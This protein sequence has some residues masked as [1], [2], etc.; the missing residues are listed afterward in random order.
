[1][2]DR[3]AVLC[4]SRRPSSS[5]ESFSCFG[6]RAFESTSTR[7]CPSWMLYSHRSRRSLSSALPLRYVTREPS[8][9]IFKPT[10]V[11]PANGRRI[12]QAIDGEF[13]AAG[14]GGHARTRPM[15][16][17]SIGPSYE[18]PSWSVSPVRCGNCLGMRSVLQP[19]QPVADLLQFSQPAR[20]EPGFELQ[21]FVPRQ[22]LNGMMAAR[23]AARWSSRVTGKGGPLI[24][25]CGYSTAINRVWV[26]GLGQ[27]REML[28]VRLPA[29]PVSKRSALRDRKPRTRCRAAPG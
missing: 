24:C 8:G 7:A 21:Y 22:L 19:R 20:L 29:A 2:P 18:S 15:P 23:I 1:M 5:S 3:A 16:A 14:P 27:S 11:G 26:P 10:M 6:A 17:P 12:E 13:R 9:E 28:D 4:R 25:A